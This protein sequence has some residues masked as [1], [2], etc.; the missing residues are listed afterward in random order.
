MLR[1]L[2][3]HVLPV[4]ADHNHVDPAFQILR[5]VVNRLALAQPHEP[6]GTA[7]ALAEVLKRFAEVVLGRGPLQLQRYEVAGQFLQ[8]LAI[9]C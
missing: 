8:R 5:H 9:C 6:L 7:L 4:G 3:D 1:Q 2:L